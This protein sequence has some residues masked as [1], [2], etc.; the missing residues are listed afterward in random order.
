MSQRAALITIDHPS[1]GEVVAKYLPAN[2][3]VVEVHDTYV[4]IVGADN[5]GWT[6]DDYVI[7]RLASGLF[8]AEE[9]EVPEEYTPAGMRQR[10][11]EELAAEFGTDVEEWLV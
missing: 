9:T 2:Y 10:A 3:K 8:H 4:L 7:P 5:A 6:L 1:Q 11:A